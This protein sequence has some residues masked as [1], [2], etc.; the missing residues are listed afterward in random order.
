MEK[1][2]VQINGYAIKTPNWCVCYTH[3]QKNACRG[4]NFLKYYQHWIVR[5]MCIT[6]LDNVYYEFLESQ[7]KDT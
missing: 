7:Q 5:H 6:T 1:I 4:L 2:I 3:T